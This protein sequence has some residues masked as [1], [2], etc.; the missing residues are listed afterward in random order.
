M[1][2]FHRT[3]RNQDGQKCKTSTWTYR[4][5][6]HWT[7][8]E[9]ARHSTIIC[10]SGE[11]RNKSET[12]AFGLRHRQAL[13]DG[14]IRP[15][16]EYT[17]AKAPSGMPT[18]RQYAPT[19]WPNIRAEV[20]PRT[21]D[22]YLETNERLLRYGPIADLRL[23]KIKGSAIK[24][25]VAWRLEATHGNSPAAI[26]A[27]LRTLRRI[28][29]YAVN[30]DELLEGCP[31]I[32]TLEVKGRDRVISTEEE[33]EYLK[34]ATGDLRDAFIILLDSGLRPDSELF[35][36]R[37]EAVTSTH[38]GIVDAKTPSG[39]RQV[40]IGQRGRAVL[41]MRRSANQDSPF[42]F[43]G[44]GISGHLKTLKKRHY[45]ACRA[46]RVERFP[47]YSLRHT[48]ATRALRAG[49]RPDVL[50]RWMGHSSE[51][52]TSKYYIHLDR[53]RQ[54][55]AEN[56]AK[57]ERTRAYVKAPEGQTETPLENSSEF[58]AASSRSSSRVQ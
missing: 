7:G 8:P 36:L 39:I 12:E 28:L 37:W 15:D 43:P 1:K 53:H 44:C 10:G 19:V 45:A 4:F 48:F 41:D 49:V 31:R 57:L 47:I 5:R 13:R 50:A 21:Y 55:D 25:Y 40:P 23:D 26:N 14:K 38:I 22:F 20:K 16:E 29:H 30:E 18:L 17:E 51:Y 2:V 42:V 35:P 34:N 24:Q 3:Y 27:E 58:Q 6:H 56:L 11:T 54:D 9:G 32:K 52:I 46:A 33:A